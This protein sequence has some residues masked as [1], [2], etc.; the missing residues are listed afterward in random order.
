MET[1]WRF[2][3]YAFFFDYYSSFEGR[4]IFDHSIQPGE[5]ETSAGAQTHPGQEFF[6]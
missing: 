6:L 5:R 1:N 2:A 4:M 3:G